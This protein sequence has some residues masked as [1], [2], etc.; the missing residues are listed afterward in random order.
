MISFS[1]CIRSR[2]FNLLYGFSLICLNCNHHSW[3]FRPILSKIRVSWAQAC[4]SLSNLITYIATKWLLGRQDI[5][6]KGMIH[7]WGRTEKDGLR[8]HHITQNS[9]QLE[10]YESFISGISH[11]LFKNLRKQQVT[12]LWK[13]KLDKRD[14]YCNPWS[15]CKH[16]N[17]HTK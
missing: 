14:Y 11:L 5:L 10:T 16:E 12:K 6:G 13:A 17:I 3:A 7:T 4:N 8:F 1:F 9:A 2:T 15:F